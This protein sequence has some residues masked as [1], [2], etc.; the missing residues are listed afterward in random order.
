MVFSY[1]SISLKCLKKSSQRLISDLTT[2]QLFDMSDHSFIKPIYQYADFNQ[3][4]IYGPQHN[5]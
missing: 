1:L 5:A 3:K 2:A 4:D